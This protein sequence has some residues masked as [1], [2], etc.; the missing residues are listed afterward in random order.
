[1]YS[2][3]YELHM[4][5]LLLVHS[6]FPYYEDP[7]I[8]GEGGGKRDPRIMFHQPAKMG[9]KRNMMPGSNEALTPIFRDS[10]HVCRCDQLL[11]IYA[12]WFI[13]NSL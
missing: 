6:P 9:A 8:S 1:M 3:I 11:D 4:I 12:V 13:R 2:P 10:S 7:K 5:Q